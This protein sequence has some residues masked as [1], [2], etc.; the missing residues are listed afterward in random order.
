MFLIQPAQTFI[1]AFR[2]PVLVPSPCLVVGRRFGPHIVTNNTLGVENPYSDNP[3]V[4]AD[5]SFDAF[6]GG[7]VQESNAFDDFFGKVESDGVAA[8]G[9]DPLGVLTEFPV[10]GNPFSGFTQN[11][12]STPYPPYSPTYS[13]PVDLIPSENNPFRHS[14][15]TPQPSPFQPSPFTQTNQSPIQPNPSVIIDPFASFRITE[16]LPTLLSSSESNGLQINGKFNKQNGIVLSLQFINKGLV[17]LLGVDVL[18]NRNAYSLRVISKSIDVDVGEEKRVDAL[19]DFGG[20]YQPSVPINRLQ[21]AVRSDKGLHL[22]WIQV[23]FHVLFVPHDFTGF[24]ERWRA[25][26]QQVTFTIEL[27]FAR[28]EAFGAG[29]VGE[30][31][32]GVFLSFMM[33]DGVWIGVQVQGN[34]VLCKSGVSWVLAEMQGV[35]EEMMIK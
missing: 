35:L 6:G 15:V 33:C 27:D 3:Q 20:E 32:G 1:G 25:C 7:K 10:S 29:I 2:P 31:D 13:T 24:L 17:P 28:L 8:D 5:A 14:V 23:P 11:S 34:A 22:F 26:T 12:P 18:F 9:L 30:K 21:C 16:S 4:L 19:V